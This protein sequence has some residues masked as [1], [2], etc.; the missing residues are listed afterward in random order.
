MLPDMTA[1]FSAGPRTRIRT[2]TA[3]AV[4]I[5]AACVTLLVV[6]SAVYAAVSFAADNELNTVTAWLSVA[7]LAALGAIGGVATFYLGRHVARERGR[8]GSAT[9]ADRA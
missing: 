7:W 8:A 5:V 3:I 2:V 9:G 6:T 4:T 1:E